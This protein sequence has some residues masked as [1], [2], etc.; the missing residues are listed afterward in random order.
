[1]SVATFAMIVFF[2]VFGIS[3]FWGFPFATPVMG[4]AAIVAAIALALGK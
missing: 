4:I 1:M 2:A 3:T